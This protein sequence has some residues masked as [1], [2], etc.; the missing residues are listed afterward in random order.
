MEIH[1]HSGTENKSSQ[2]ST[3][4]KEIHPRYTEP[5]HRTQEPEAELHQ[6]LMETRAPQEKGAANLSAHG[7]VQSPPPGPPSRGPALSGP[8]S[9]RPRS[10][11]LLPVCTWPPKGN[12]I[13]IGQ[14]P[15]MPLRVP[16]PRWTCP[17][18]LQD[19]EYDGPHSHDIKWHSGL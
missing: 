10:R 17:R 18:N 16:T 7:H 4:Q 6:G 14:N 2:G 9:L 19:P 3:A 5:S 11:L 15:K 8:P 1:I 13:S 12:L